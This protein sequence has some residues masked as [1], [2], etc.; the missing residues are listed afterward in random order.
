MA[1][2]LRHTRAPAI[3]AKPDQDMNTTETT[4]QTAWAQFGEPGEYESMLVGNLEGLTILRD[5]IDQAIETGEGQITVETVEFN[6]VRRVDCPLEVHVESFGSK[7]F[8]VGCLILIAVC[9]LIFILGAIELFR[10]LF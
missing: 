4:S 5:A 2:G 7:C 10:Q 8:G 1:S 3:E 6:G 9:F